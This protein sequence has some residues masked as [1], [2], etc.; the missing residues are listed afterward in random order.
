LE[1]WGWNWRRVHGAIERSD[2]AEIQSLLDNTPIL[3]HR[4][5]NNNT[6]VHLSARIGN[7]TLTQKYM[8]SHGID[9]NSINYS[10]E[11][12]LMLAA[13][14][15][16]LEIVKLLNEYGA[17]KRRPN[18]TPLCAIRSNDQAI[19]NLLI[20]QDKEILNMMDWRGIT[21]LHTAVSRESYEL[22]DILI[23]RGID[24]DR[25]LDGY[26]PLHAAL[27]NK[28]TLMTEKILAAGD[29]NVLFEFAQGATALHLAVWK[30]SV[31]ITRQILNRGADINARDNGGLTALHEAIIASDYDQVAL[32][33]TRGAN[34]N[35]K[36]NT[37]ILKLLLSRKS[38][39]NE[40]NHRGSN[41]L[42]LV[43]KL[44]TV[45]D[46]K[47]MT[48]AGRDVSILNYF[49]ES[50]LYLAAA[51]KDPEVC[52]YLIHK[53]KCNVNRHCILGLYPLHIACKG[54]HEEVATA[55]IVAGA[56]INVTCLSD[57]L[58]LY[59]VIYYNRHKIVAILPEHGANI[60]GPKTRDMMLRLAV[61]RR[62]Q[63]A[64]RIMVKFLARLEAK[65]V[66]ISPADYK[67]IA[68]KEELLELLEQYRVELRA[69]V[70]RN[71]VNSV[72]FFDTLINSTR[73]VLLGYLRNEDSLR[74]F[75]GQV[76][77]F[78]YYEP[79]LRSNI[80]WAVHRD[81]FQRSVSSLMCEVLPVEDPQH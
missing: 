77:R 52:R 79:K 81:R 74:N 20:D 48:A 10:G 51:N 56:K 13:E 33:V 22:V 42:H 60:N 30:K 80:N 4:D 37:N 72:T 57:K 70:E 28:D 53:N 5:K 75:E 38:N 45:E 3:L 11:M 17:N 71:V 8:D 23:S 61:E 18:S 12:P 32:L 55:L 68:K 29:N 43:V 21:A 65:G 39:V 66:A 24:V 16:Q 6:L 50:V 78:P 2:E 73:N 54:E 9:P 44:G 63:I 59:N 26:T 58:P 47:L 31:T 19:L 76:H 14:S 41:P 49:G 62:S 67:L 35:A 25:G 34:L 15:N 69:M 36:T 40:R 7:Y 27:K 64:A 46:L 1:K